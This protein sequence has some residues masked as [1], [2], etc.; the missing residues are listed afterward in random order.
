M[1]STAS[2]LSILSTNADSRVIAERVNVLIR[3]Y[4]MRRSSRTVAELAG[5]DAVLGDATWVTDAN[6]TWAAGIGTVVVGGGAN[7][8]PVRFDG[9]GWRI[10]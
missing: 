4:N 9:S 2:A 5:I 8:V 3:E 10:G 6:A 1:S 7:T